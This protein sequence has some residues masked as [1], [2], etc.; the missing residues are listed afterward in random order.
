MNVNAK[1]VNVKRILIFFKIKNFKYR[2]I[3]KNII[4]I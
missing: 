3:N 4:K 1:R 2:D